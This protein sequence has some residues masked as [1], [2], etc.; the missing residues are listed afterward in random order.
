MTPHGAVS[1]LRRQNPWPPCRCGSICSTGGKTPPWTC[2]QI[3]SEF[4]LL[5]LRCREKAYSQNQFT[6]WVPR[7]I[8]RVQTHEVVPPTG[9]VLVATAQRADSVRVRL[10]A[11]PALLGSDRAGTALA[12]QHSVAPSWQITPYQLN[13][14]AL[15]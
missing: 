8:G 7:R 4:G 6:R 12:R 9:S 3:S 13:V 1:G 5:D 15:T 11:I 10:G 14:F 2:S